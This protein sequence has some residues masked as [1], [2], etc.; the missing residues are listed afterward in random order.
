MEQVW[1][2]AY[3]T[4]VVLSVFII[5]TSEL[6][7]RPPL[8]PC[9]L[10]L[11]SGRRTRAND[12]ND[13]D[14]DDDDSDDGDD[15]DDGESSQ[16]PPPPPLQPLPPSLSSACHHDWQ[17]PPQGSISIIKISRIAQAQSRSRACFLISRRKQQNRPRVKRCNLK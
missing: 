8:L 17:P 4:V 2:C 11:G 13:D 1:Y 7:A 3:G 12:D 6:P 5:H 16:P 15:G 9:C 10:L 14:D